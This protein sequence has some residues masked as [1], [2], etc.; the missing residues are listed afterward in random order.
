MPADNLMEYVHRQFSQNIAAHISLDQSTGQYGKF[1]SQ[2]DSRLASA[3]RQAGVE[4]LY[5]HQVEAF[6]S[7]RSG[8]DTVLVSRTASGKTLSFLLPILDDY[9]QCEAPFGVMLLYPTKALSRDQEGTLGKLLAASG[10]KSRLGTYDG[11]TPREERNRIQSQADFMIT[12]PDMLHS[13][14]L[15]NHN[16]RWRTFLSR[17]RYVV[18]DEVHNYRGAFGSHIA[19]VMRRLLRV[20]AM[21]GS[22]PTFVCSS[23]TIGNPGEHVEALL[24]RPF[25]IVSNDGAPRPRRELYMINPSVVQS[26][27]HSLYRKGTSSISIP[28]IREAARQGVRTICFCRARQ[29]V[30]RLCRAVTD[31]HPELMK[32]VKPYR[33]GLLPNERR[34]LERDL[35]SGKVNTIISTNAL[36]LGIDIGDLELCILSG[37]PGSMASFW[38]QA[39][40]VGRR[41]NRAMIAYL[42]RDT[43]IDQYLVNHP[44]F[45]TQAPIERAWLSADNPYILLQH[46]PCAAHEHPLREE[47]THFSEP[48]YPTALEILRED[49][50]LVEYHGNYR[51]ALRDYPTR[52]VNLRGMTDY[53]VEIYCGTEVIGELDPIGARGTLYKDAIYQHLGKRYMSLELDLD[54][55]LCRVEPVDVDYYTEAVWDSRVELTESYDRRQQHGAALEFGAINVNRQPKLYKK[56]RERSLENIGY[57]PIT[58]DSFTYDTTGFSLHPSEAWSREVAAIDKRHIGA[59]LYGLSYILKRTA[60][61][62]CL[63]DIQNIETD[64]SL[65]EIKPGEWESA[66]Y[67]FDTIEGGVG[68]AEKIL[69]VF[70]QALE[71]CCTIIDDCSCEAGCPSCVTSLPPGVESI[72]M[73]QLLTESNASVACTRS[74]L[75]MLLTGEIILPEVKF[76]SVP[77][78]SAVSVPEL[79]A[80]MERLRNR[81]GKANAILKAKRTR[82]H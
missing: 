14:I 74:L 36:E 43:P 26:H 81:L 64:V 41:G 73:E 77:V 16:R 65:T 22:Q 58:L 76:H 40:R 54:Q 69:E 50:T 13:G 56:I 79:D 31:G 57:G 59:A 21:H 62:L 71:L 53:N 33:G 39:G 51:Y 75:A 45:V 8:K 49:E 24:Q 42:A 5:S 23:A 18:I 72:E 30:E 66:L 52:G 25:H 29:Q 10:A 7:I 27:G 70:D 19:N 6:E 82:I 32:K 60:P 61:S 47:E 37:H 38:Q 46:L 48:A 2:L 68:Y 55:K 78:L 12:N 4:Q 11:D 67:L 63:G 80:D 20:C 15:P 9:L 17:L 1:P 34:Q 44:E 3:L 35:A 28:L